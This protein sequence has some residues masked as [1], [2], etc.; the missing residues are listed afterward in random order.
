M[1]GAH[2]KKIREQKKI[3]Q[4]EMARRMGI[5]QNAYSKIEN[6]ITQLTINHVK[7]I[8]TALDVSPLELMRGDFILQKPTT[9]DEHS[10]TKEYILQSIDLLKAK[11]KSLTDNKHELYPA[12]LADLQAADNVLN[13]IPAR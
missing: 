2:I 6:N 7:L 8:S 4:D 10:I 13:N 11:V 5:S 1:P 12:L 9:T 3:T